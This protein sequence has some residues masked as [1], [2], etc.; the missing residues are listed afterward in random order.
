MSILKQML[1]QNSHWQVNKDLARKI[2]IEAA[3]LLSD[4]ID[5]WIFFDYPEWFYNTSE[6]IQA[7]TTL[8]RKQQERVLKILED[9]NLIECQL[10]GMPAKRHFKILEVNVLLFFNSGDLQFVQKEQT[11]MSE[12][13]KQD[14][15]KGAN[16]IVQKVQTCLSEMDNKIRINNNNKNKN[17]ERV[18]ALCFLEENYPFEYEN[19]LMKYQSKI[20]DFEKAKTDFNLQFDVENRAYEMKIIFSRAQLFFNRWIENQD[21][22]STKQFS[23]DVQI[24]NNNPSRKRFEI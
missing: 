1:G 7:D 20:S 9:N 2:G 6:N 13:D 4:L 17:K 19:L 21:R 11:S 14:C 3:I 24:Q 23:S 10:Q 16:K 5:K 18:T 8:S 15:P 12:T 22:Y